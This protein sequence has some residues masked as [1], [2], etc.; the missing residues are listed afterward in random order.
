MLLVQ[1]KTILFL[2]YLVGR[3]HYTYN[4]FGFLDPQSGKTIMTCLL[5]R[6]TN[7]WYISHDGQFVRTDSFSMNCEIYKISFNPMGII[8]EGVPLSVPRQIIPRVGKEWKSN[9]LRIEPNFDSF[10]LSLQLEKKL[11]GGKL[12][13]SYVIW[14]PNYEKKIKNELLQIRYENIRQV[15]LRVRTDRLEKLNLLG[16]LLTGNEL[17]ALSGGLQFFTNLKVVF[18][19]GDSKLFAGNRDF[20]RKIKFNNRNIQVFDESSELSVRS[21]FCIELVKVQQDVQNRDA[22]L[23]LIETLQISHSM[24]IQTYY[25]VLKNANLLSDELIKKLYREILII[26]DFRWPFTLHN[27]FLLGSEDE[28]LRIKLGNEMVD[29]LSWIGANTMLDTPMQTDFILTI[30]SLERNKILNERNRLD[31]DGIAQMGKTLND[32]RFTELKNVI[33]KIKEDLQY[34]ETVLI[35]KIEENQIN[36]QMQMNLLNSNM[37]VLYKKLQNLANSEKEKGRGEVILGFIKTALSISLIFFSGI[38]NTLNDT[39]GPLI[40][41]SNMIEVGAKIFEVSTEKMSE[42]IKKGVDFMKDTVKDKLALKISENPIEFIE[43]WY[44]ASIVYIECFNREIYK[45]PDQGPLTGRVSF[46]ER[47]PSI[48]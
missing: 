35:S 43:K 48:T 23:G 15:L 34:V 28:E 16:S 3:N 6:S 14:N 22:L 8:K 5:E 40:D 17:L 11:I 20:F 21:V 9:G 42:M 47:Y 27:G 12:E 19:P 24:A 30:N 13:K 1:K 10:Y 25:D 32:P 29:S 36:L 31:L 33:S 39:F 4:S 37:N 46:S 44:S 45:N 7:N 41:F 18:I 2:H 26:D 38:G